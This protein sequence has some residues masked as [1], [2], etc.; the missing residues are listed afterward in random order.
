MLVLTLIKRT[1]VRILEDMK[2]HYSQPG[3][4]V[5][6]NLC[7][8]ILFNDIYFGSIVGGSATKH[9][10]GRLI[11]DSLNKGINN[12]FFHLRALKYPCRNFTTKILA[13]Y[14]KQVEQDWKSKYNDIPLWHETLVEPPRTGDCYLRDKWT[15][16]GIT[17]GYTCK[18]VAGI[19]TD[20]WSGRRVWDTVNLR[21][22]LVFVRQIIY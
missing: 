5:G 15:Q 13:A 10:P 19:G 1:D 17:K 18:R 4:F 11:Q 7:Y 12:I 20:S 21:P 6:R 8:A 3:G 14:R 22:K 2:D 16:V 9:L